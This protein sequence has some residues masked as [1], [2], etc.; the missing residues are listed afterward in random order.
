MRKV[1]IILLLLGI[2]FAFSYLGNMVEGMSNNF[3]N[4]EDANATYE[5]P[6]NKLSSIEFNFDEDE[7]SPTGSQMNK[8]KQMKKKMNGYQYES[9]HDNNYK[10]T[11]EGPSGSK[12]IIENDPVNQRQM[13][14]TGEQLQNQTTRGMAPPLSSTSQG[15]YNSSLPKG[16]PRS[17]I[18]SGEEDMYIL[19]SE[20]VP[21]VCPRCPSYSSMFSGN[22]AK[23][24]P[25]CPP[26]ARCPEH[27]FEC[28]KVPN[29]N[30]SNGQ[31]LPKPLLNNFSEFE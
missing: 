3:R 13:V 18:P 29:Y 4:Q 30:S 26:C 12:T 27:A 31:Y 14:M 16:I 24:C 2:V 11:Y 8:S 15:N 28:K 25:P 7:D 20:V 21:P 22:Q 9:V 10:A 23:K 6:S 5:G 1:I 19:K 17:Q